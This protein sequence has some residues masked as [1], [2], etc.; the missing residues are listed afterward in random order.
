MI[1]NLIMF[2]EEG[3]N[4]IGFLIW[5]IFI[6][7]MMLYGQRFQGYLALNEIG[8]SLNKLKVTRD[9]SKLEVIEFV[10]EKLNPKEDPTNKINQFLDYFTIMPVNLDPAGIVNK[11]EHIMNLRDH[12]MK[13]EIKSLSPN[14]N[15]VEI[16]TVD[17]VIE[18]GSALNFIYKIVRHFYLFGKRTKSF[19]II[20]QL[21]M[22]MPLIMQQVDALNKA[23]VTFKQTQPIGDGIGPMIVGKLMMNKKTQEI[24]EDTILTDYKYNDRKIYLMKAE[25]PGGTVGQPG[26]AVENVVKKMKVKL[27]NIIMIDAALK[28]EGEKTG[29]IAEGIGAAIGGIGVDRFKIEEVAQK[30]NI[31]VYAIVIKQSLVEAIS[32]MKKDIADSTD[33]V[34]EIT[35]KI[36]NEK[37]EKGD[38]ILVIGVG[39]TIGVAQ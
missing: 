21:Q 34:I 9:K 27:N 23:L 4:L 32:I 18:I 3:G 25:G 6:L 35:Q 28:L 22:I 2:P 10:K 14:S 36:I 15:K 29:S 26:L 5:P 37:S 30:N 20:I 1:E 31:P 17:N 11:I 33:K 13:E 8:R 7:V 12:R 19:F 24:A 16:S 39:N 38:N